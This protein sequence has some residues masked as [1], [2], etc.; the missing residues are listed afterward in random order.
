[1]SAARYR[2]LAAIVV[3]AAGGTQQPGS[4]GLPPL[5]VAARY[6]LAPVSRTVVPAKATQK[7]PVNDDFVQVG[8]Q[9][10]E[11]NGHLLDVDKSTTAQTDGV[12]VRQAGPGQTVG[13]FSYVMHAPAGQK[14]TIRVDEA[15]SATSDYRVLV[16]GTRVYHR[17]SDPRQAGSWGGMDGLAGYEFAVPVAALAAGAPAPGELRVTF[18]NSA[19]PRNRRPN[20]RSDA[21]RSRLGRGV[22]PLGGAAN[23]RCFPGQEVR[24]TR[25]LIS[26]KPDRSARHALFL[27]SA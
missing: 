17:M 21:A 11:A 22:R 18:A 27:R 6:I 9:V 13:Y 19:A 15:G 12:T 26:T 16:N 1:M 4:L 3:L 20:R 7:T 10:S 8:D 5:S 14:L 24:R 25:G 2:A 23:G